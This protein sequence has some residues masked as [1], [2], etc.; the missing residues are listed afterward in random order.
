MM[1]DS[2][3][4]SM[5]PRVHDGVMVFLLICISVCLAPCVSVV[6]YR[7]LSVRLKG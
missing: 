2:N 3:P 1:L 7:Y 4:A 5:F 6:M